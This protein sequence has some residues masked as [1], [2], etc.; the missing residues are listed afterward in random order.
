MNSKAI[1]IKIFPA[2]WIFTAILSLILAQANIIQTF[3]WMIIIFISV[4]FHEFGHALTAKIFGRKPRIELVG[5]GGVTYHDGDK[6][7]FWK[8]F[9]ITL[10]GPLFGLILAFIAHFLSLWTSSPIAHTILAQ[11]FVVNVY[12]TVINLFPILPLDGGQLLRIGLEKFFDVKGLRYTFLVSGILSLLASLGLFAMQNILGGAIFFL[13]A[14]ENFSN[15]RKARYMHTSD[16]RD[17]LK[18]AMVK[19]EMLLRQGLQQEALDAFQ[20]VRASASGGMLYDAATQYCALILDQQGRPEAAYD[21]LKPLQERL[22]PPMLMLLHRLA[23]DHQDDL[24]VSTIGASVFQ[25]F[26]LAEVA[27]RNA[28]TA[29]RL[30]QPEGA[31]GWLETSQQNGVENIVDIV[32]ETAFDRVRNDPAFKQFMQKLSK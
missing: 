27:L 4:L 5:M 30:K 31:I 2:Y 23:F 17:E 29:A 26:P 3:V 13:F 21:L 24:T 9:F 18:E 32:K 20:A 22:D 7:S 10:N 8:Q 19:A 6:L 25:L 16:R 15:F 28:Y 1:P 12:W 14:F 11:I